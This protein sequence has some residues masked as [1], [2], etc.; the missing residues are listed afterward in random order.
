[1]LPYYNWFLRV[2]LLAADPLFGMLRFGPLSGGGGFPR[3]LCTNNVKLDRNAS[4]C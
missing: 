4:A 2:G 3:L 1:M